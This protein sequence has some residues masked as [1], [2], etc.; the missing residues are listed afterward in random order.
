MWAVHA[1]TCDP[2]RAYPY[3]A[4][5]TRANTPAPAWK[6]PATQPHEHRPVPTCTYS[7]IMLSWER[8]PCPLRQVI[9][10]LIKS[11]TVNKKHIKCNLCG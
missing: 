5:H 2:T 8:G 1:G 11:D 9:T 7:Q 4:R 10:D 6:G 3:T